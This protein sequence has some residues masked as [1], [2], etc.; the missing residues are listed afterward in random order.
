M[1]ILLRV[2][3]LSMEMQKRL[4][5]ETLKDFFCSQVSNLQFPVTHLR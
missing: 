3:F 1:Y 5:F 2:G 4:E